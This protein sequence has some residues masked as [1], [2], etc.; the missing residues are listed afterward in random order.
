[1]HAHPAPSLA[2]CSQPSPRSVLVTH[3]W[4][5]NCWHAVSSYNNAIRHIESHCLY[6]VS[7]VASFRSYGVGVGFG[8]L[9][10][11]THTHTHT[12]AKRNSQRYG[13][14]GDEELVRVRALPMKETL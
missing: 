3:V 10:N 2:G 9:I 6:N 8:L 1:M 12:Q 13:G 7:I 14:D 11:E 5:A 4:G